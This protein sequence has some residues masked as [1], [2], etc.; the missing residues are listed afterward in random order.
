M[1]LDYLWHPPVEIDTRKYSPYANALIEQYHEIKGLLVHAQIFKWRTD[2]LCTATRAL[3][4]ALI[5]VLWEE[6]E[7]RKKRDAG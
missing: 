1:K 7:E 5:N 3:E 4:S 6:D 2:C